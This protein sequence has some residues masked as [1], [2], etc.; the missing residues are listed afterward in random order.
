MQN[1]IADKILN[2]KPSPTLAVTA[3]AALLKSQGINIISLGAGEPDFDTPEN[4]KEAGINA[5]KNGQTKY[6]A[7]S[8]IKELKNAICAKLKRENS[9]NFT[10]DEILVSCGAK[11]SI[12][13]AFLASLNEGDEV[14]I[15]AP[16]WV[17]YPDMVLLASGKPVII[18][19]EE[20]FKVSAKNIE[21]F[22]TAK[23]KWLVL[24]SPSN[25]TGAVYGK[26]ELQ[27]IAELLVKFPHLH[28]MSDDIYE[29]LIYDDQEFFT[30]AQIASPEVRDRILTINGLSKSYSM[31]GWR[32]GYAAGRKDL[33]EAMTNLQSQST[34]NPCSIAQWAAV[35]ALNGDQTFIATNRA[36]FQK[37]RDLIV[38][39]LNK[40]EGIK[41]LNPLGAF[42]VMADCSSFFG[43]ITKDGRVI[44]DSYVFSEFLLEKANVAVV[45]G[46]AFG[47]D[48]FFRASYAT[49]E[50]N[51]IE[52][53]RQIKI[54][55]E[56]AF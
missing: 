25:P 23:T 45:P 16:Y 28:I 46:S 26:E 3:K 41:C 55:V 27:E 15:P 51:L 44:N 53:C 24:N 17:S 12:F 31:T 48:G 10:P 19:A 22:I 21:K 54:A 50:E 11:H 33:I 2:I 7:V 18:P 47:L 14:L 42:Y 43:K 39:E 34:S 13:N 40:I 8:G 32:I 38:N 4:V 1:I 37:R 6:T 5:I 20:N 52:A 49:S 56:N 30:M 36:I 9:V 35:E 29:H